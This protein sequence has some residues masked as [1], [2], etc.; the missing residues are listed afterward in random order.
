MEK[1]VVTTYTHTNYFTALHWMNRMK[2]L[3]VFRYF[4]IIFCTNAEYDYA[5]FS[6]YY[7]FS[8]KIS[9][10][11]IYFFFSTQSVFEIK[12]TKTEIA[13]TQRKRKT[14]PNPKFTHINFSSFFPFTH[15]A[16]RNWNERTE[17][18]NEFHIQWNEERRNR[19]Q[20]MPFDLIG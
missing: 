15:T 2:K 19:T 12:R 10:Y 4:H 18:C 6:C 17:I 20:T 5:H 11:N 3:D 8:P 13:R 7:F 9:R 16:E 14:T 1:N